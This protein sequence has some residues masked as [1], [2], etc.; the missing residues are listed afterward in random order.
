M[1]SPIPAN[2]RRRAC[3]WEAIVSVGFLTIGS[4]VEGLTGIPIFGVV[5]IVFGVI[6]LVHALAVSLGLISLEPPPGG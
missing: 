6:G 5:L 3:F 1:N 4:A 2:H